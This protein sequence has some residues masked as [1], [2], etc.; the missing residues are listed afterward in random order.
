MFHD[1][2]AQK[3]WTKLLFKVSSDFLI[4]LTFFQLIPASTKS[5]PRVNDRSHRLCRNY[6]ETYG[7]VVRPATR[8]DRLS[9]GKEGWKFGK[10]RVSHRANSRAKAWTNWPRNDPSDSSFPDICTCPA[11]CFHKPKGGRPISYIQVFSQ[12]QQKTILSLFPEKNPLKIV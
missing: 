10:H 3:N 5:R 1:Q 4:I 9:K 11:P 2:F 6:P 7:V 12:S 8:L